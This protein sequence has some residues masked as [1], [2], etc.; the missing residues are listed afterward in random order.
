MV[1]ILLQAGSP[2]LSQLPTFSDMVKYY[3][4]FLGLVLFL[5]MV[6]LWLQYHW[7]SRNIRYKDEE[8]KRLV[9]REQELHKRLMA[10]VDEKL[11]HVKK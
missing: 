10:L 1:I 5:L 4:P 8:I 11:K 7:F 2:M 6:M 3:G 9:D